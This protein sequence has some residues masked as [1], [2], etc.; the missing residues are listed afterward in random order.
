MQVFDLSLKGLKLI[1]PRVFEDERGFFYESFRCNR[2][3]DCGIEVPFVQDNVSFSKKGTIRG[4][5]FQSVPGQD[6]LV[7]CIHGEIW[8]V[9]VD[10]RPDSKT[11]LKWE[12]VTLSD[13]NHKQFFIPKGFAHGFCVLSKEA[14]VQYKVSSYYNPESEHSI[15]WDDPMIDI[16]WPTKEPILSPRD[17]TSP[18]LKE[19]Q[20][21]VMDHR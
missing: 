2:Y 19:M 6:K 14:H 11:Y 7:S 17:Q 3:Q 9:A 1:C 18:L 5:H 13:K 10:L 16:H 21:V 12:A 4:L 15:R 20:H 8:D